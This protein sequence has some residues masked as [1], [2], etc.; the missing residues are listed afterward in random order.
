[1]PSD[2]PAGPNAPE[3]PPVPGV[4]A[5]AGT[6]GSEE[7]RLHPLSIVFTFLAEL[8]G[9]VVPGLVAV[10][11]ANAAGFAWQALGLIFLIP[12]AL[13]SAGRYFRFRYRFDPTELVIR[14]GL[15]SRQERHIPYGRIQSV[16]AVQ[17]LLHRPFGVVEVRVETG[18]GAEEPEAALR[19][20]SVVAYEEMRL[21]HFEP[22]PHDIPLD[23]VVTEEGV[24]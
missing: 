22:G 8:K 13:V 14:S 11:G 2:G 16:D 17:K 3:L 20:L 9:W 4:A 19:V 6:P 24:R 21:D 18:G 15:L 5:P 10:F 23:Y 12:Q 1:M 7:H